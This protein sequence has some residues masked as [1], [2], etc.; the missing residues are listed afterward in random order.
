MALAR[1]STGRL[2]ELVPFRCPALLN[3][4]AHQGPF[5]GVA[6]VLRQ[7]HVAY[8]T[9]GPRVTG[10]GLARSVGQVLQT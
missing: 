4:T 7:L 9:A 8:H 6:R 3:G 2:P 5:T 10:P 1:T